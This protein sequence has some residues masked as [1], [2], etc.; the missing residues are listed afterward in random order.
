MK[1]PMPTLAPADGATGGT[2]I[3]D[4]A[5]AGANAPPPAPPAPGTAQAAIQDAMDGPPEWVPEKYWDKDK[6]QARYEDLG[7]GYKSLEKL[8]S[9]DKVPVP[10][11][12]D[13]PEQVERWY[14][15]SGRPEKPDEYEFSKPKEMP[16][17]LNY[18]DDLEKGFRDWAHQNGLN[19]KQ[20]A[21]AHDWFV[22]NQIEKNLQWHKMQKERRAEAEVA[23]RREMGDKYDGFVRS[24]SA[25]YQKY[26]DPEFAQYLA[27][28]GLG[29][30]PRFVKV[31]GRIAQDMSGD[32]R[33]MGKPKPQAEPADIDAA[34]SK[35][36]KENHEALFNQRHPDNE[37]V[38]RK[39][40]ELYQARYPER[41]A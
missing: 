26:A 9:Y 27:E 41:D 24:T 11:N 18:D 15:A 37:M 14:K 23:L 22:K 29:N 19:K 35:F 5:A 7:R 6:K 30:D 10:T 21:N 40:N 36:R 16:P 12:W 34:I 17:D 3:G 32:T 28:T 4:I 31:F 1:L 39:L 2:L 8:L 20:A 33:L 13:D 38:T 25:V